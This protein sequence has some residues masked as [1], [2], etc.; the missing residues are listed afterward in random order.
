MVDGRAPMGVVRRRAGD[1]QRRREDIGEPPRAEPS[2]QA[3]RARPGRR[4]GGIHRLRPPHCSASCG[5]S[6]GQPRGRRGRGSSCA[7]L[8][9]MARERSACHELRPTQAASAPSRDPRGAD[10]S[11]VPGSGRH[12][13]T[14]R[15]H[16]QTAVR[17]YRRTSCAVWA[18]ATIDC[19]LPQLF[20]AVAEKVEECLDGFSSQGVANIVWAFA[21]ASQSNKKLFAAVARA[22][23]MRLVD[24]NAQGHANTAWAFARVG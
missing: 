7:P 5:P 14:A 1:T 24:F 9:P 4:T 11:A 13:S 8:S 16:Q 6:R 2:C 12:W 19:E 10:T 15:S 23:E 3:C 21:K 20:V 18:Y 17:P 22:A